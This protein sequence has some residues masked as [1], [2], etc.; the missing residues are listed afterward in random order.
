MQTPVM[1]ALAQLEDLAGVP[2]LTAVPAT[3]VL[4]P[5][6]Q[7][8]IEVTFAAGGTERLP[9]SEVAAFGTERGNPGN[10]RQVAALTVGVNAP[11]LAHG[12]EIVDTP[13]STAGPGGPAPA[14][15]LGWSVDA[16]R[17]VQGPGPAAL[18]ARRR[19]S[20]DGPVN[21]KRAP[22]PGARG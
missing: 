6:G 4:A 2:P 12:A 9:L 8:D 15:S 7:E 18:G 13:G 21:R 19:P 5:P 20:R 17:R 11:L 14:H 16:G 3:V 10:C 22:A 1:A